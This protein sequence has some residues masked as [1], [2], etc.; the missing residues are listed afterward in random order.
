[1]KPKKYAV[2]EREIGLLLEACLD[3][4]ELREELEKICR[5][6]AF[7][8]LTWLWG[9]R[10]YAR[11]KVLFRPFILSHFSST[12]FDP[13]RTWRAIPWKGRVADILEAWLGE[14]EERR[15]VALFRL[16]YQWRVTPPRSWS[17]DPKRIYADLLDRFSAAGSAGERRLVLEKFGIWF[18]LDEETAVRL[19]EIDPESAGS[20]ILNHL[21]HRG[22][23]SQKR[24]LWS[25]LYG[26]AEENDDEKLRFT[27][28]RRQM[29]LKQWESDAIGLCDHVPEPAEL[30]RNLELRHPETWGR[31]LGDVYYQ[32]LEKRGRD[33]M[34]YLAKH[35]FQTRSG[36]FFTTGL[37]RMLELSRKREWFDFWAALLR[38]STRPAEFNREINM[39]LEDRV[40]AEG[41]IKR[42]LIMLAGVSREWNF[43][44]FGLAAI[45]PL[46]EKTALKFHDRFPELL[47]GPFKAAIGPTWAASYPKL[48]EKLIQ[49]GDED[50]IDYMASRQI[51]RYG[52][53]LQKNQKAG[54]ER[55]ADYYEDLKNRERNFPRRACRVLGQIPAYGIY[56]YNPL[57]RENRL[58]RL[59]MARS[60]SFYLS[61]QGG[62]QDI[63]EGAE[64]HVQALAYRVLGLDDDRARKAA[65]DNSLILMGTLFRPLHRTTRLLAFRALINAAHT[66][67]LAEKIHAKARE[68]LDLPDIRYPKEQLVGLI[69]GLLYKWPELRS[70]VERPQIYG[71]VRP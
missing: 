70:V 45:K 28:Y 62:L 35:L 58:A 60:A 54:I 12:R 1:M 49:V 37:D 66:P 18:Q 30:I 51:T 44:G 8:G 9:P 22:I 16:L 47:R 20:F 53:W 68:A 67:E 38:I 50:L 29:P 3:D 63:L 69:G 41:E 4:V 31:D 21:P 25:G 32:M 48:V 71:E 10:L 52:P 36:F 6:P 2:L 14:V 34:P 15:D 43:P 65:A 5:E 17:P 56:Q 27:L 64:I 46:D 55:L 39:L 40:L 11:N 59:L 13:P 42:R 19:Y 23:F 33:V 7:S 24:G 26:L 61:D 57:I